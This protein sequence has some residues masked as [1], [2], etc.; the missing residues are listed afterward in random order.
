MWI[1]HRYLYCPC[2]FLLGIKPLTPSLDYILN[3]LLRSETLTC[4][5]QSRNCKPTWMCKNYIFG[6]LRCL[7]ILQI[8]PWPISKGSVCLFFAKKW[9]G[10]V[11]GNCTAEQKLTYVSIDS[12]LFHFQLFIHTLLSY[13]TLRYQNFFYHS[14]SSLFAFLYLYIF[15]YG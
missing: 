9:I 2:S 7:L 1:E 4:F 10:L 6:F 8:P 5:K 15:L 12:D 3:I 13:D 11:S 14:Y